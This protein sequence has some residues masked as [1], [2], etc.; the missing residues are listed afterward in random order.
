M[1]IELKLKPSKV[2]VILKERA[3]FRNEG[4]VVRPQK[5]DIQ[6]AKSG[7][8]LVAD[9][10]LSLK[11]QTMGCLRVWVVSECCSVVANKFLQ[12]VNKPQSQAWKKPSVASSLFPFSVFL[13]GANL[14]LATLNN[15]LDAYATKTHSHFIIDV[16]VCC[17]QL[18]ILR[19]AVFVHWLQSSLIG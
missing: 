9:S 11:L 10:V 1:L 19:Q 4:T 15:C 5:H 3:G 18:P 6:Q 12:V 8:G 14:V 17:F 13:F 16:T 2:Q 7:S